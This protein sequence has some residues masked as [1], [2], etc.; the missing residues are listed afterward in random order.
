MPGYKA[1]SL[2]FGKNAVAVEFCSKTVALELMQDFIFQT[3]LQVLGYRY[4]SMG[5]C[6]FFLRC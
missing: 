6:Y 5:L 4:V 3:L 1:M 2:S